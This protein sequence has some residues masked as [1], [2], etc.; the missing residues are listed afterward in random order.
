M[1]MALRLSRNVQENLSTFRNSMIVPTIFNELKVHYF[2]RLLE[3]REKGL[4]TIEF[5]TGMRPGFSEDTHQP[6]EKS[7]IGFRPQSSATYWFDRQFRNLYFVSGRGPPILGIDRE[8]L[9]G[10]KS[11]NQRPRPLSN[12]SWKN[13]V[14]RDTHCRSTILLT[15]AATLHPFQLWFFKFSSSRIS[16]KRLYLRGSGCTGSLLVRWQ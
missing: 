7:R 3:K 5:Q 2:A 16:M 6:S 9:C 15:T 8:D 14:S 11:R 10:I 12:T 13:R 1:S 4:K